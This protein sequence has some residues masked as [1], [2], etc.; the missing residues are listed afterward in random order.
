MLTQHGCQGLW[1]RTPMVKVFW[2]EIDE[3]VLFSLRRPSRLD[4]YA[5]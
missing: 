5:S 4:D 1:W 2:H 3:V